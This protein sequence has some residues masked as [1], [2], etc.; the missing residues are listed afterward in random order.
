ME[1]KIGVT[2][3]SLKRITIFPYGFAFD[4]GREKSI[5]L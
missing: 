3:Y 4:V 1:K 2:S 5:Q